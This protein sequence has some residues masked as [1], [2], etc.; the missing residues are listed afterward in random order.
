MNLI[1]IYKYKRAEKFTELKNAIKDKYKIT[2]M[3]IYKEEK[4]INHYFALLT[5]EEKEIINEWLNEKDLTSKFFYN[6][7]EIKLSDI[8]ISNVPPQST[9]RW[10]LDTMEHS[11]TSSPV[12]SSIS[13]I[14]FISEENKF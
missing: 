4:D 13:E 11:I 3:K 5:A 14:S 6:E 1:E 9:L 7:E 2:A 8:K 12:F 10:S